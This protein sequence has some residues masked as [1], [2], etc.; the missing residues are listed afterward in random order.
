M[1]N[2][3]IVLV[4]LLAFLS[5]CTKS[6]AYE[7]KVNIPAPGKLKSLIDK[8][9]YGSITSLIITGEINDKDMKVIEELVNLE[10]LD[11]FDAKQA[12]YYIPTLTKLKTLY[13][14]QD[15]ND[16]YRISK[17]KEIHISDCILTNTS[18]QTIYMTSYIARKVGAMPNCHYT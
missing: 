12:F 18:L 6:Y 15:S 2:T 17:G 1:K 3:L 5:V 11:M 8:K 16:N 4:V 14:P 9:E 10:T 13:L 7:K